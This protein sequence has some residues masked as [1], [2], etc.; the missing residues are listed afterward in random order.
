MFRKYFVAS[1]IFYIK[2]TCFKKHLPQEQLSF[3]GTSTQI[4]GAKKDKISAP[5]LT[6]FLFLI[7]SSWRVLSLYAGGLLSFIMSPIICRSQ[8]KWANLKTCVPRK[9]TLSNFPKNE[10]FLIP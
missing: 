7:Y 1:T 6:D 8:G 4:F 5:Y 9:Q 3:R 2:P 10:E